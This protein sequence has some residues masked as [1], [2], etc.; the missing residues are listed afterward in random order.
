MTRDNYRDKLR[1][2]F[3]TALMIGSVFGAGIAFTGTAAA[4]TTDI[5]LSE[6]LVKGD[7]G[8]DV[9]GTVNENGTVHAFIDENDDGEYHAD[10]D[11]HLG[12]VDIEDYEDDN[13]FSIT[14]NSEDVPDESGTYDVSI[15][16]VEDEANE[17]DPGISD[18]NEEERSAELQVDADAPI[19]SDESPEDG[20]TIALQETGDVSVDIVDENTSV[21]SISAT[22]TKGED[23]VI[24]TWEI[25]PDSA[26]QD[27]IEFSDNELVISPG[28]GNVPALET[29]DYTVDVSASDEAGNS[30]STKFSF[31]V[32]TDAPTADVSQPSEDDITSDENQ[33]IKASVTDDSHDIVNSTVE[34]D[35]EGPN[36]YTF[37]NTSDAWDNDTHTFTVNPEDNENVESFADGDYTVTVSGENDL[38]Y[39]DSATLNFTVDTEGPTV[40]SVSLSDDALNLSDTDENDEQ[41]IVT[42]EEDDVD[43]ESVSATVYIDGEVETLDDFSSTDTAG[44]LEQDLTLSNDGYDGVEND[45]AVV[46]VTA[47]TDSVDIPADSDNTLTNADA[48]AS[49]ATFEIDTNGPTVNSNNLGELDPISGYVNLTGHF[50]ASDAD[51]NSLVYTVEVGQD[52]EMTRVIEDPSNLDTTDLPEGVHTLTVSVADDAGNSDS[53]EVDPFTVDNADPTISYVG[54]DE[55]TGEVNVTDIV[56][57]ED[58][59]VEL[60]NAEVDGPSG[61]KILSEDLTFDVNKHGSGDYEISVTA[62][63]PGYDGDTATVS[64]TF[65]VNGEKLQTVNDGLGLTTTEEGS[66]TLNVSFESD[67]KLDGLN[68]SV[69]TVD[70]YVDQSVTT[71]S[72]DDFEMVET[73]AGYEYSLNHTTERDGDFGALFHNA[74]LG[75]QVLTTEDLGGTDEASDATSF[76]QVDNR[77]AA[78]VDADVSGVEKGQSQVQVKFSEPGVGPI[79]DDFTFADDRAEVIGVVDSTNGDGV[80]TLTFDSEIQTGDDPELE[81]GDSSETVDS[82]ELEL[83]EGAN[84]VSAPIEAGDV[85]L[86]EL[87]LSGVDVIW[88]YDDGEW[89]S[90]DPSA[91]E[92]DLTALEGGQGYILYANEST[93]LDVRGYTTYD[94]GASEGPNSPS[95]ENL[96]PGWNL[97]GHFQEGAQPTD[98]ALT[99]IDQVA[100]VGVLGQDSQD[101]AILRP[102][103]SY[104]VFVEDSD[105]YSAVN[106]GDA[107]DSAKPSVSNVD[108][109]S[110]AGDTVTDGDSVTVTAEITDD[111]LRTTVVNAS[112][113]GGPSDLPL[114]QVDGDT[115]D[116]TF[117][118]DASQ[119]T[120]EDG[121]VDLTVEAIDETG[122]S[123]TGTDSITLDAT[124]PTVDNFAPSDGKTVNSISNDEITFEVSDGTS[125]V[126]TSTL[127]V[128]VEDSDETVV[129]DGVGTDDGAVSVSDDGTVSVDTSEVTLADGDVTVSADV[130]DAAGN[131]GSGEATFT[132]D[133]ASPT[134]DNFAPSDGKTVN[135]I[136]NDEITFE[137]S[138]GTSGVDTSTLSV[139]VSDS[140][141]TTAI[142]GV[143]TDDGAVSVSDDGTVSV[144]TSEVTLADGDVTV[145]ADVDDA[146][147]NTGS[148]EATFTLD[149]TDPTADITSPSSD[150]DTSSGT[151]EFTASDDGSGV[152]TASLTIEGDEGNVEIDGVNVAGDSSYDF[153]S[154]EDDTYTATLEVTDNAG[155]TDTSEVTFTYDTTAPSLD[156]ATKS[157]TDSTTTVTV[158]LTDDGSGFDSSTVDTGDFDVTNDQGDSVVATDGVDVSGI[159]DGDSTAEVTVELDGDYSD[160]PVTA[161]ITGEIL[162]LAGNSISEGSQE[163]NSEQ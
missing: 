60:A 113:L 74:S 97:I 42:F 64:E 44:V 58:I 14:A 71:Y 115:Y 91:E 67:A 13:S 77:S 118:V 101:A 85:E 45:S 2:V 106:Y 10:N 162:D 132:L 48:D 103:S 39:S 142:D 27:G 96:N 107:E 25:N 99:S 9:N 151:L 31:D 138:D 80:Y 144:D 137:V 20:A 146:A 59:G 73:D 83:S 161:E 84:F 22:I 40:D 140:E 53:V 36:D 112:A 16:Q 98:H 1:A 76:Q 57:I 156:S 61:D 117:P 15:F 12:S 35:I 49:N 41:V 163:A 47:A 54:P 145:S 121:Q 150:V 108:V 52:E 69:G 149:T 119:A 148:G 86:D 81:F 135:S 4:S 32:V 38:G 51:G 154:L 129:L 133:T 90:F 34:L 95:V 141:G 82:I 17:E 89:E 130:D 55:L 29:G 43:P 72:L 120:A 105:M 87:D 102:G 28:S 147:G 153:S 157:T 111:N 110:P 63:N 127:S 136:S 122:I 92:N 94:A 152:D 139:T 114:K 56:A 158:T 68:I 100:E 79:S 124:S 88:A 155:N 3:L 65:T 8:F 26:S 75:D 116:V 33:T 7:E 70:D 159:E 66:D 18:G 19:F 46:N 125:G 128:T 131:T 104:W 37:D 5:T 160:S 126:D 109:S 134:V 78:I 62:D 30:N 23:D 24:N 6:D 11:T 143:G 93:E 21:D 50:S 123:S